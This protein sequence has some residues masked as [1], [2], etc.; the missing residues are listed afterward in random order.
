MWVNVHVIEYSALILFGPRQSKDD[1]DNIVINTTTNMALS[2]AQHSIPDPLKVRGRR[3]QVQV[4]SSLI[5][6]QVPPT[7]DDDVRYLVTS[8]KAAREG[9]VQMNNM[10]DSMGRVLATVNTCQSVADQ[11][12]TVNS[13]LRPI[14]IFISVVQTIS[15]VR[16]LSFGAHVT[17]LRLDSPICETSFM[18]TIMGRSGTSQSYTRLHYI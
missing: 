13:C 2:P 14:K 9:V 5:W 1:L 12:D 18:R 4:H 3:G 15:N 11:L 8:L 17:K 7:G 10:L 16:P 6:P